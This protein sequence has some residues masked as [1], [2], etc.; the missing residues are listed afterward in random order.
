ME[1]GTNAWEQATWLG[2]PERAAGV[3]RG[4]T[5]SRVQRQQLIVSRHDVPNIFLGINKCGQ[6]RQM[7]YAIH[8]SERLPATCTCIQQA[9]SRDYKTCS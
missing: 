5:S 4:D 7:L 2:V 9:F 6:A 1:L 3:P 8:P